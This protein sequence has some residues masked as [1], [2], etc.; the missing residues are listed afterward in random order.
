MMTCPSCHESIKSEWHF[1]RWCGTALAAAANAP[2]VANKGALDDALSSLL[3]S[4]QGTQ[5]Q[6]VDSQNSMSD[7]EYLGYLQAG[8]VPGR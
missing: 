5:H 4:Q 1:C 6:P 2:A 7:S 8:I 3:S